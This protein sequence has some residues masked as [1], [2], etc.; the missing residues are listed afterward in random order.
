MANMMLQRGAGA[1]A[2][3]TVVHRG[4]KALAAHCR[5]A[6]ILIAAAGV[7]DLVEPEWVKPGACVIDV[8]GQSGRRENQQDHR[9]NRGHPQ[10]GC[11]FRTRPGDSRIHHPRPRRSGACNHRHVDEKHLELFEVPFGSF[12]I[13]HG[14]SAAGRALPPLWPTACSINSPE[15]VPPPLLNLG[16]H[17]DY[18]LPSPPFSPGVSP[19]GS[20]GDSWE[21]SPGPWSSE[22]LPGPSPLS[23]FSLGFSFSRGSPP[24]SLPSEP[25]LP[26]SFFVAPWVFIP[27]RPSR[28]SRPIMPA[29]LSAAM[30]PIYPAGI[31]GA[32]VFGPSSTFL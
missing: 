15:A 13:S 1:N 8:G 29:R 16:P 24:G 7:P 25:S 23:G 28:P 32:V 5:R 4:T 9:Q 11:E 17:R 19:S 10:G 3:V 30:P 14:E 12:L 27:P 20:T 2:T 31:S 26:S 21:F 18:Q 22:V 6:D